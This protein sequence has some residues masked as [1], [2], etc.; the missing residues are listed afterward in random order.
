MSETKNMTESDQKT[1]EEI[2]ERHLRIQER[3]TEFMPAPRLQSD[4]DREQLLR[5]LDSQALE[6]ERL[7]QERDEARSLAKEWGWK[8]REEKIEKQ[9]DESGQVI[10]HLLKHEGNSVYCTCG[11]NVFHKRVG[12]DT[13]F[14]CNSCD[15][16]IGSK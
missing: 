12:N 13:D 14:F 10:S 1:I 7:K 4:K 2:K 11:C 5:I 16:C 9:K 15:F 8:S 3:N 6:I